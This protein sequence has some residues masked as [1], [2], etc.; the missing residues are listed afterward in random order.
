M[1]D[2]SQSFPVAQDVRQGGILSM[3]LYKVCVNPLLNILKDKRLGFR[4]GTVYIGNPT[5]AGDVAY[6]SRLRHEL[7]LMFGAPCSFLLVVDIRQIYPTK[8][9]VAMLTHI[10]KYYDVTKQGQ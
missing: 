9:V 6:L 7:Q 8:T 2:C 5:V 10:F 3:H 4:L 1:G